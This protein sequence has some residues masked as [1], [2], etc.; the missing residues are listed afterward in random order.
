MKTKKFYLTWK[1]FVV[2]VA[3]FIIGLTIG[4]VALIFYLSSK[5]HLGHRDVQVIRAAEGGYIDGDLIEVL[6]YATV[7]GNEIRL[8]CD[9]LASQP[10]SPIH[11]VI[12]LKHNEEL[13]GVQFCVAG[14]VRLG[15]DVEGFGRSGDYVWI[16]WALT[17]ELMFK[18]SDPEWHPPVRP[19]RIINA[20]W[21][22]AR[23][24]AVRSIFPPEVIRKQLQGPPPQE[25]KEN[26][27]PVTAGS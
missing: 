14:V 7:K 25:E 1:S 13:P 18:Y 11:A 15:I 4:M 22:N 2:N 19:D 21:V 3:V 5:K 26:K 8:V 6:Y 17:S 10:V 16:I 20:Y 9:E 23:T 24:G 27:A 12:R